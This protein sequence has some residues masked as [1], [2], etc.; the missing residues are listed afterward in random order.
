[1]AIERAPEPAQKPRRMKVVIA[2][3]RHDPQDDRIYFK[4]ALS[5]A[6]RLEV[7][8]IAPDIDLDVFRAQA[9]A[10]AAKGVDFIIFYSGHDRALL[11]SAILRGGGTSRLGRLT[12]SS[13]LAGLPV[14]LIDTS[15]AEGTDGLGHFALATSPAA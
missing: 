5:L 6:K 10:V 12:D 2:T 4:Q 14:Q 11:A 9:E 13:A 7:V 8:L 1:M 3:V 15:T